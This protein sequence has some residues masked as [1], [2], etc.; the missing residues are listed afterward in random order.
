[1]KLRFWYQ[2]HGKRDVTPSPDAMLDSIRPRVNG[3]TYD[4][5]VL[6]KGG[7]QNGGL[8]LLHESTPIV[9]VGRLVPGDESYLWDRDDWEWYRR[10]KSRWYAGDWCQ[11]S[12]LSG[13]ATAA[14]NARTKNVHGSNGRGVFVV[15]QSNAVAP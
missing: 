12:R 1:M 15:G 3:S 6:R 14:K 13:S 9:L 5:R 2:V 8:R 7:W 10:S 11:R 4:G